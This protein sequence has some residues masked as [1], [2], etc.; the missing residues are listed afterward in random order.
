MCTRTDTRTP[1]S[2]QMRR[3]P[4]LLIKLLRV[5]SPVSVLYDFLPIHRISDSPSLN[6][7]I[8]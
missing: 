4:D 3:G 1:S 6:D 7:V 8:K 5:V 2:M